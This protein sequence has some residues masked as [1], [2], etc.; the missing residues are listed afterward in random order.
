[1]RCQLCGEDRKLIEAHILPRS[2]FGI[3][4]A[5][6]QPSRLVT[7][8]AGRYGR[9]MPKGAY[10]PSIV[11]E[12]CERRFSAWDDYGAEL[13]LQR[14]DEFERLEHLGEHVGYRLA[15]FDY[16]RLKMFFLSVLWRAAV[17]SHEM[18][19]AV[20]VGP[21]GEALKRAVIDSRPGGPDE[22]AVALQAF[23]STDVGMLNPMAERF[24][25]VRYY[26]FYLSHVIAF[27]KV[28]SRPPPDSLR[29]LT[30]QP[31]GALWLASKT[32][33]GSPEREIMRNLV[34]KDVQRRSGARR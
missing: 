33:A 28:D 12:E 27:V 31:G 22:F 16:N 18:F 2:F 8:V 7:N 19:Y 11:C 1:M 26:R 30:I 34:L 15:T 20:K 21:Y 4:P 32:F 6:R 23:D 24:E 25:G 3:D 29:P 13:F 17:S 9:K 10:D 5:E 14:W